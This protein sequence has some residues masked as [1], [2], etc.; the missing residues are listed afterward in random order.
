[1]V[2]A[3]EYA[4]YKHGVTCLCLIVYFVIRKESQRIP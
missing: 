3:A 1:L 4:K 2:V